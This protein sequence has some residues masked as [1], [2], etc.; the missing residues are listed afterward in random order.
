MLFIG[1]PRGR[2]IKITKR[3]IWLTRTLTSVHPDPPIS[4]ASH[5]TTHNQ[6][7]N[8]HRQCVRWTQSRAS[9]WPFGCHCSLALPRVTLQ[10]LGLWARPRFSEKSGPLTYCPIWS[11]K[12]W[13]MVSDTHLQKSH[14]PIDCEKWSQQIYLN[15]DTYPPIYR[16]GW[17][18][19]TVNIDSR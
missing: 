13:E 19:I 1:K 14:G 2:S 8:T 18:S 4:S 11:H 10:M 6:E 12:W 5:K 3:C 9:T 17:W 7:T 16:P 15:V